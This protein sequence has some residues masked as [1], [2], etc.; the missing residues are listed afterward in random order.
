MRVALIVRDGRQ[1]PAAR[2]RLLAMVPH[3]EAASHEVRT[4]AWSPRTSAAVARSSA[5]LLRMARW[6]DVVVLQRPVQHHAVIR[7][8]TRVNPHL[9]VDLDD[10]VWSASTGGTHQRI[11]QRVHVAVSSARVVTVGSNHLARWVRSMSAEPLIEVIR[12]PVDLTAV[13]RRDEPPVPTIVWIGT[14]S[15]FAD[16]TDEVL[17]VLRGL[18][19]EGRARVRVVSSTA[20]PRERLET[21]L[22]QWSESTEM[23]ALAG[24]TIGIMPLRD[25]ERSRGRCGYKAIQCM[26]ARLPVVASPVG[27]GPELVADGLTGY[28]AESREDWA[29]ALDEL[30]ADPG[31]AIE[32]GLAGRAWVEAHASTEVVGSQLEA[33]L[34]AATSAAGLNRSRG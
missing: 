21:E 29:S 30:L 10:A 4:Q 16:F 7:A 6:A 31:A 1:N 9:V 25:D 5:T 32:A 17:Q 3:L 28:L 14:P 15:N 11:R 23:G 13:P 20:F 18:V 22:V 33:A 12:S 34:A 19:R 27:A 8:L 2:V 26:A 24:S